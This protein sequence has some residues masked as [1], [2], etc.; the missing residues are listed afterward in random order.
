MKRNI[1]ILLLAAL[2]LALFAGCGAEGKMTEEEKALKRMTS[3]FWKQE[4]MYD[5]PIVLT[6]ETDENG[7][8]KSVPS[9]PLL[10]DALSVEKIVWYFHESNTGIITFDSGEYRYENGRI[11]AVG[12]FIT[13]SQG[14]NIGFDTRMPY[15]TDRQISGEDPFPGLAPNTSIPSTQ[16][17]L[18]LPF[19]ESYQIVQMQLAVT[20]RHTI[21]WEGK[22]PAFCGD[23]LAKTLQK[24]KNKETVDILIY[25]DSN[26]TGANSSSYLGIEP[27]LDTWMDMVEKRLESEYGA[28]VVTTNRALGGWT[29]T[30]ALSPTPTLGWWNGK[31]TYRAGLE[32]M[33]NEELSS[34][35]PDLVVMVFG[36]ND[37]TLGMSVE[38][39]TRNYE[40]LIQ[41]LR[42]RNPECEILLVGSDKENPMARD[43]SKH[44]YQ[45]Y[46][47]GAVP[48]AEK[49]EGVAAVSVAEMH[50][51]DLK[52]KAYIETTSNGV[53]HPNDFTARMY[54]ISILD[55]LIENNV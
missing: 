18:Y 37:A 47:E 52:R 16:N 38:T 13:D 25:G 48:I 24:L 45:L 3:D 12:D 1:C 15:V 54:A 20:Y 17:G 46:T 30:N 55:C 9:A 7:F 39:Y 31:E 19:T 22:E 44:Q 23:D 50:M 41:I 42:A 27:F 34:Y 53:N 33:L 43:Q 26:A 11:Y 51:D 6:A 49:T 29:T 14:K 5:E 8:L 28:E 21:S 4:T 36:A 10:F 32:T 40:K 35:S 2:C